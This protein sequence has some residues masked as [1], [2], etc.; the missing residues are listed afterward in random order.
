MPPLVYRYAGTLDDGT[1]VY[2]FDADA[3]CPQAAPALQ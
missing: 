1:L 3:S 2:R